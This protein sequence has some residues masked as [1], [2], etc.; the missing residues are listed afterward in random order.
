MAVRLPRLLS[1]TELVDAARRPSQAFQ[2]YWQTFAETIEQAINAIATILGITEELDQAIRDNKQATEAAQAA[3][4]A[5]QQAA[6]DAAAATVATKREA[7]LQ[8]S[9]IEPTSVLT[10]TPT[11]INMAAH[12]RYYADG[13]SAPVNAGSA[14]ATAATETDYVSYSDPERDGGTVSLIV[15]TV[16]PVQTGDTHVVGAV[17]I[18]ATGT[19]DGGEGPRRPGYVQAKIDAGNQ[20]DI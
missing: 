11:T 9:Y 17:L 20:T 18:P 1:S 16:A 12:V 3:A 7:A 4:A 14:P 2:R 8:G 13:T 10:A 5:A 15:S 19:S 6:E